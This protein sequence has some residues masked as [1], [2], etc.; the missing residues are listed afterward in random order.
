MNGSPL[1]E[2][3]G[4]VKS[5]GVNRVLDGVDLSIQRGQITAVIGK[6]GSGKSV[7]AQARHRAFRAG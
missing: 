1:I 4:V 6:S 3:K 7:L 2:L 5:L